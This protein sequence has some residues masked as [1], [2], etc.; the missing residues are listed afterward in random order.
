M[1]K[2]SCNYISKIE[3]LKIETLKR[4]I[5]FVVDMVNG[6]AKE[7]A[8]SDADILNV[9][10]DIKNLLDQ[11]HPS[12][13]ICDSHDLNAREFQAFPLHCIKNTDESKVIS[14]LQSYVKKVIFKNSTNAF[15]CDGVQKFITEELSAYQDII[16]VGCCSDICIMQFA[17]GMNTYL[18][19]H[20][21]HDKRVIVPINMIETFD[22]P[23]VHDSMKWNEIACDL[24][25]ANAISVVEMK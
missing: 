23:N 17:L 12:I 24:M 9:V 5:V 22:I 18:N 16:I 21:M 1:A 11:V 13:F 15:V 2:V 19:E 3:E 7:G 6:F 14:E 25:L 8:L 4:P 10:P 20:E